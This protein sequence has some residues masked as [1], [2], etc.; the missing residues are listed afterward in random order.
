MIKTK[1]LIAVVT[2]LTERVDELL[3]HFEPRIESLPDAAN[4]TFMGFPERANWVGI[5]AVPFQPQVV[6]YDSNGIYIYGGGR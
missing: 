4:R 6:K 1:K 5:W 3:E 2:E